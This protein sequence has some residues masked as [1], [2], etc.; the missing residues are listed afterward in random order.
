MRWRNSAPTRPSAGRA[1]TRKR[2]GPRSA[3]FRIGTS[4]ANGTR[5]I[6][7]PSFGTSSTDGFISDEHFRVF[8]LSNWTEMDVWQYI[9]TEKIEIPS[10]YFSHQREIV[11]PQGHSPG[12][13]AFQHAAAGRN[14]READGPFSHGGRR[15]LH[16]RGRIAREQSRRNYRRSGGGAHHRT[17]RPRGRQ[18]KRERDGRPQKGRL[19]LINFLDRISK[20]KMIL[21]ARLTP[22]AIPVIILIPSKMPSTRTDS[23]LDRIIRLR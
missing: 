13:L 16:R 19:F 18:A 17:G 12:E 3:S 15:H 8:P 7:G 14:L 22:S 2:R 23:D 10:L 1:G 5:R 4:S 21:K 11:E 6:S 9:A 20:I